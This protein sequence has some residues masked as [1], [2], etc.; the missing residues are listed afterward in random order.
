MLCYIQVYHKVIQLHT[1][2]RIYIFSYS[3][4]FHYR[5]WQ[6]TECFL[7]AIIVLRALHKFTSFNLHHMHMNFLLKKKVFLYLIS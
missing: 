2:T 7:G 6:N 1:H 5:L 3:D 4:S